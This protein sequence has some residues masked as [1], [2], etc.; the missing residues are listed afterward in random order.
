MRLSSLLRGL[1]TAVAFALI[2]SVATAGVGVWTT[3][4]PESSDGIVVVDQTT[5]TVYAGTANGLYRADDRGTTWMPSCAGLGYYPVPLSARAGTLYVETRMGQVFKSTDGGLN[6]SLFYDAGD[7]SASVSVLVDPF[8]ASTLYRVVET[9]GHPGTGLFSTNTDLARSADA[10]STWASIGTGFPVG[11]YVTALAAD[12][13]TRG[14]L[15]AATAGNLLGT[16]TPAFCRSTDAGSTWAVVNG[17]IAGANSVTVSPLSSSTIYTT[18]DASQKSTDGGLT[19]TVVDAS[20]S[21]QIAVDGRHPGRLFLGTADRGVLRSDDGGQSWTTINAGLLSYELRIES[22]VLDPTSGVLFALP[23]Y[24]V[25]DYELAST[26]CP[27]D[28]HTLCLNDGRFSVSASFTAS[29]QGLPVQATAVPLTADTGYFWFFDVANIELVVK[30]LTGCAVND[31][32]WVFAGGLTNTGVE[33]N[34]TDTV[35]GVVQRYSNSVGTPF[36]PIQ[37]SSAFPCP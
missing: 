12:P 28:A 11:T 21:S 3:N 24:G 5:G 10:G 7:A 34:V 15:Y 18:G 31:S 6:C 16:G 13:G 17:A 32:Y 33:L 30:V 36:Q 19:F 14:V 23:G 1:F 25:F 37:D 4:G 22:L 27:P 2:S 9:H 26:T 8:D 29:P 20:G 35:T